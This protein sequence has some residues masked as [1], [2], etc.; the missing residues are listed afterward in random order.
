MLFGCLEALVGNCEHQ[1]GTHIVRQRYQAKTLS[2]IIEKQRSGPS[3]HSYSA[4]LVSFESPVQT[5]TKQ[6]FHTGIYS[7]SK[8]DT[9]SIFFF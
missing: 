5:L 4:L 8:W 6:W 9:I 3:V 7:G 1:Q 2:S